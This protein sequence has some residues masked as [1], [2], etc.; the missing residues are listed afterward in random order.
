MD[1][2]DIYPLKFREDENMIIENLNSPGSVSIEGSIPTS[3]CKS[4]TEEHS[5][6]Q[7]HLPKA[8][9]NDPSMIKRLNERPYD[10]HRGSILS[11][12]P[13]SLF[14]GEQL[15]VKSM[16]VSEI[17]FRERYQSALTSKTREARNN[18]ILASEKMVRTS[19]ILPRNNGLSL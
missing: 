3:T 5:E 4:D 8:T 17:G 15:P 7:A 19:A 11:D 1:R 14:T 12:G 2:R 18:T 10:E 16:D 6:Q 9:R 13:I